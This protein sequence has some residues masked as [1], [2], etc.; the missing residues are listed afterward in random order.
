M[1]FGL[2]EMNREFGTWMVLLAL[3]AGCATTAKV[4]GP[5]EGVFYQTVSTPEEGWKP[6]SPSDVQ[7]FKE[8]VRLPFKPYRVIG[9]IYISR[10]RYDYDFWMASMNHFNCNFQS[11][12]VSTEWVCLK[13]IQEEVAK[14]GGD[15]V[16]HVSYDES[17]VGY[18]GVVVV[19]E[20]GG[21]YN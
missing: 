7:V 16:I 15:A 10:G 9:Y 19:W 14:R 1:R 3:L 13:T 18:V 2:H 6:K 4:R 5:E 17:K 11:S 12:L 8:G 20:K 21:K